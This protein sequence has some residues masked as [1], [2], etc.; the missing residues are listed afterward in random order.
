M[1]TYVGVDWASGCWIAFALDDAG[2]T[3]DGWAVGTYPAMLNVWHEYRQADWILVDVPVGLPDDGVRECDELARAELGPRGS[4]VFE[5]P[6]RAAVEADSYD[7]AR[8]LNADALGRGISAQAWGIVPR[9]REVDV[10]LAEHE[11]A[12]GTI[13]ESHPELCFQGLDVAGR[14]D[15]SKHDAAGLEQR[16]DVLAAVDPAMASVYDRI[17]REYVE[18]DPAFARPISTNAR[19]DVL[20]AMALALT[21]RE[22]DGDFETLPESPPRDADGRR[23]EIVYHEHTP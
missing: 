6:C 19:D 9:I 12:D 20:D 10:F 15:A 23:M 16:K 18:V 8:D 2:A 5:T 22:A 7:E 3:D 11:D 4:S 13:R 14:I 17:E 1:S 21:A